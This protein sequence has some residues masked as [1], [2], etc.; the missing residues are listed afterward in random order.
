MKLNKN[1]CKAIT[2]DYQKEC[3]LLTSMTEFTNRINVIE[4][5]KI[6]REDGKSYRVKDVEVAGW[7]YNVTLR[8]P[9]G[10]EINSSFNG[11]IERY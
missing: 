5:P 9:F 7:G 1:N 11:M 8:A 3:S 10:C 4:V 6:W 2:Y